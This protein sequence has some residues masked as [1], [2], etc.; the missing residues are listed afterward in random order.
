MRQAR[1]KPRVI[2]DVRFIVV[3]TGGGIHGC[4]SWHGHGAGDL[5]A[6]AERLQKSAAAPLS[7]IN[8]EKNELRRW[9]SGTRQSG[10]TFC[11]PSSG[12]PRCVATVAEL[13]H[14]PGRLRANC[15]ASGG[16]AFAQQVK[17]AAHER[18][19]PGR[20]EKN[21]TPIQRLYVPSGRRH[22]C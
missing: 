14:G 22:V 21:W 13:A 8:I 15:S 10:S 4:Q 20:A 2:Q 18:P 6:F 17:G 3:R 11:R 9:P 7:S 12:L 1:L 19:A 16:G 5:V